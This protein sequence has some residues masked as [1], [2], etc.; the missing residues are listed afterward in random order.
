MLSFA[1]TPNLT[2]SAYLYTVPRT[3]FLKHYSSFK[4]CDG[5]PLS[6]YSS[7][8]L[9]MLYKGLQ[10]LISAPLLT[11][12]SAVPGTLSLSLLTWLASTGPSVLSNISCSRFFLA[13]L[14]ATK[15]FVICSCSTYAIEVTILNFT[16]L[17]DYFPPLNCKATSE[18]ALVLKTE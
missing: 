2:V 10:D 18:W 11:S 12:H 15:S 17:F 14:V 8:V 3:F 1:L 6:L 7:P 5:F 4:Y 13:F 16:S 9:Y